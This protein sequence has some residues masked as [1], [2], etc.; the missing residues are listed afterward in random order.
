MVRRPPGPS[1]P[2]A[3]TPALALTWL[4]ALAP[5][6]SSLNPVQ[7]PSDSDGIRTRFDPT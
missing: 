5:G 6:S 4:D 2:L 3:T 7:M 1:G